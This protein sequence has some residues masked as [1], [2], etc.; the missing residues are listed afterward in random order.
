M[1]PRLSPNGKHLA[2]AMRTGPLRADIWLKDIERDTVSRLTS[3]P[4]DNNL[5]VWTP[6]GK[7]IVFE[8]FGSDAPGMYWI[9]A[10][11]SGEPQRLTDGKPRQIPGSFSPDGNRL[12][13]SQSSNEIW[14]APV[15]GDRDHPIL[16]KAELF[17]RSPYSAY[18]PVFSPD[19]R[20]VAYMSNETGNIEVYVRP[21][22]GPGGRQQI[23]TGGGRSPIWS[24]NGQELFF[25]SADRRIM[26]AKY[27]VNGDSFSANKPQVWS[28]QRLLELPVPV[29]DLAPDGKRVAGI[30]YADGTS[31]AKPLTHLTVLLNF[32]DELKRR[33]P[34]GGK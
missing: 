7:S 15:E 4:G 16:G 18:G 31:E 1:S 25:L 6:D 13:Y 29:Y 26:V 20:W 32:S 30:L 11:G 3:L 14:T 12:A 8:A 17:L 5:E 21:F 33:V 34:A 19:G 9:R 2:F 24:R 22:P 23:S 27:A 28:D 10:D